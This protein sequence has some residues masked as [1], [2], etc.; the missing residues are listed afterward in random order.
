M[1]I[2]ERTVIIALL[3]V[4]GGGAYAGY[5]AVQTKRADFRAEVAAGK[6]EIRDEV[7]P[8]ISQDAEGVEWRAIYP[9]TVPMTLGG[10]P[11]QVSVADE[12]S[13][14]IQGLSGTPYLP[15]NVVKLFAFGVEGT[16]SI[17]M[18]DMNYSLDIL[19]L[20]KDGAIIYIEENVAPDT[21]PESFASPTPA[22]FVVEAN[23]G[24]VANNEIVIGDELVLPTEE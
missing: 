8:S 21:F 10:V 6:F 14:R 1:K 4:L 22:W 15:D 7:E 17:W 19:W 18:K 23:A 5:K 9:N 11:V 2:A 20:T 24:F 16:H 12:L 3:L 13:E